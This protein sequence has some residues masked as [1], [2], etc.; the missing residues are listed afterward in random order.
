MPKRSLSQSSDVYAAIATAHLSNR[1]DALVEQ[2][3]VPIPARALPLDPSGRA[4]FK[5]ERKRD[6]EAQLRA[7]LA[8]MRKSMASFLADRAPELDTGRITTPLKSFN[9]RIETPDDR[10]HF[11]GTLA[12]EGEWKK[13]AIPHFGPPLGRAVT[14]YRT[15]FRVTRD[16]LKRGAVFAHFNGVDYKAHVFVNGAFVG[17]HEGFFAPFEFDITAHVTQGANTL[18]VKVEN[19]AINM[20]QPDGFTETEGDKI[21]AA[22]GPG[23]DDPEFGWHHCPPGM[24]IYQDVTIEARARVFI[25]DLF[26]RPLNIL[27]DAEVW[28]ELFNCDTQSHAVHFDLSLYGQNFRKTVFTKQRHT[29]VTVE[30]Q[31]HGDVEKN[32]QKQTPQ[33]AGPGVNYY[34]IPI[35]IGEPR[36]WDNVSPWLY[37][38]QAR[39][40]TDAAL[41]GGNAG[42]DPIDAQKVQFGLRTFVQAEDSKP[43]GKFFLNNMEIRLRGA[44]SMGWEQRS[45]MRGEWDQLIDDILLAKL[46]HMNFFR[47]T[48]RPVQKAFYEYCDRLG[49]MAQSDLPLFGCL[50]RNQLVEAVRQAQEMERL[51]R[52]NA[53]SIMVSYINEPFPNGMS[54]PHRHLTR[55]EMEDFF[56][57]ASRAIR[58]ANPDR[59][60]KYVDGDYDP[61]ATGGMPDNHCYSGWYLGHAIDL[62]K[63]NKGYWLAVKPGWQYGCGEFG[64]EGLEAAETM[65]HHYPREWLPASKDPAAAWTP[66]GISMA[67]TGRFHFLWFETQNTLPDWIEASQQHQ[68]WVVRLMTEAFRRDARM[69]TFAWHLFIDAWPAGWMKTLV[70]VD[71]HPKHAFFAYRDALSPLLVSLRT[72]RWRYWSGE[73]VEMEAWLCNDSIEVR[74]GTMLRYQLEIDGK[75]VASGID[76]VVSASC[77]SKA[78]GLLRFTLP[79]TEQRRLGAIRAQ[80]IDEIGHVLHESVQPFDIFPQISDSGHHPV[81]H[82][83]VAIIEATDTNGTSAALLAQLGITPTPIE[84]LPFDGVVLIDNP[85]SYE[86]HR[87]SIDTLVHAGATAIM[88]EWPAGHYAI[89]DDNITLMPGGMGSPHFVS[90]GTGHPLVSDY[91]VNDFKFWYDDAVGYVTPL[92]DVVVDP[93]PPGWRAILNSGNGTWQSGWRAVPAVME[94]QSGAGMYRLCQIKLVDRVKSNPPAASFARRLLQSQ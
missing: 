67:Q 21:Y 34:R 94:K 30:I 69:N 81:H 83:A 25:S 82:K 16:M 14:Y 44:N 18:L 49:M 7:D 55:P 53:S 56:D 54:K 89:G 2:L 52:S 8:L 45:I 29:P 43:K 37:Q 40:V 11:A 35:H 19:D 66:D 61:P 9:W 23:Y 1:D 76:D 24:G 46:C 47:I 28:I 42:A 92:L 13:V 5:P 87:V 60:I 12:G 48:Q 59:V 41:G 86:H 58:I 72:D 38:L 10:T 64:S 88:L 68:A 63:L 50:R 26:V 70:D 51:V 93:M 33:L 85:A 62:G 77:S 91:A 3:P 36:L 39:L 74:V 90:R 20:G 17:S 31:G 78:L 15:S 75:V 79:E 84:E 32:L 6:T 71:R 4:A 80:W 57:M 22:S 27:G 73:T 65:W